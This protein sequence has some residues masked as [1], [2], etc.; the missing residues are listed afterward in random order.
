MR[1]PFSI[2]GCQGKNPDFQ[3]G[4]V[5]TKA[6]RVQGDPSSQCSPLMCGWAE[7]SCPYHTVSSAQLSSAPASC[8]PRE[9][10]GGFCFRQ[11]Q[12]DGVSS[13]LSVFT[14]GE[15]RSIITGYRCWYLLSVSL[16]PFGC[17][18]HPTRQYNVFALVLC[19]ALLIFL[20]E[21]SSCSQS[22]V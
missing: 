18:C 3:S 2:V 19:A 13:P 14:L 17:K 1:T 5:F 6:A 9:L 11:F 22:H 21:G 20:V 10:T 15:I 4:S 8:F 12:A 16:I 7:G